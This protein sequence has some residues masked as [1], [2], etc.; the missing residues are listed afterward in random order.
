MFH[1]IQRQPFRYHCWVILRSEQKWL[2]RPNKSVAKRKSQI[3]FNNGSTEVWDIGEE[4]T[5]ER[6]I[7]KKAAKERKKLSLSS[8]ASSFSTVL[9]N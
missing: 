1:E 6:P 3:Q 8:D 2:D 7:G 4:N 5:N 9:S